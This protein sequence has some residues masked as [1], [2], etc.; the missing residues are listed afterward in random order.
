[1]NSSTTE[2][3]RRCYAALPPGVQRRARKVYR[4]WKA[5]PRHPSVHF[6]KVGVLWSARIDLD[7]RALATMREGDAIWLWIGTHA[8]YE[9][10]LRKHRGE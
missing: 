10:M 2:R 9:A 1:M 7:Y 8:E 3:F 5:N 4:L 6:K